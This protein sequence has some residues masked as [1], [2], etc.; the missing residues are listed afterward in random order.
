VSA[1][2]A[3]RD[4]GEDR[5]RRSDAGSRDRVPIAGFAEWVKAL[6]SRRS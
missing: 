5:K 2:S 6:A 3:R 1:T 4:D